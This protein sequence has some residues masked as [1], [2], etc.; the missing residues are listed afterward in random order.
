MVFKRYFL[1]YFSLFIFKTG[2][3]ELNKK[4]K[5][6]RERDWKQDKIPVSGNERQANKVCLIYSRFQRYLE[7]KKFRPAVVMIKPFLN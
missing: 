5:R 6:E 7:D 4:R 1:R 2:N 3:R